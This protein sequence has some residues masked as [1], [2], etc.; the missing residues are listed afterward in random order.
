MFQIILQWNESFG[1]H[2]ANTFG[3]AIGRSAAAAAL[4]RHEPG[5]V[6]QVS[7]R[8]AWAVSIKACDAI[9]D[10]GRIA[11]LRHLPITDQIDA[12]RDLLDHRIVNRRADHCIKLRQVHG[13]AA[14]RRKDEVSYRLRARQ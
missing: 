7:R 5:V 10:I 4:P 1:G 13:I 9:L 2:G 3:P 14:F 8:T 11:D 12:R 6:F